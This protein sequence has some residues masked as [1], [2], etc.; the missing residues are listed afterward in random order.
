MDLLLN[1]RN[2]ASCAKCH[3]IFEVG[4][5]FR[6]AD[7]RLYCSSNCRAAVFV[8]MARSDAAGVIAQSRDFDAALELL[9]RLEWSHFAI[10]AVQ[11][12]QYPGYRAKACP[13]CH[14]VEDNA[15]NALYFPEPMLGHAGNCALAELLARG[16]IQP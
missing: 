7:G 6:G 13:F 11:Y 15:T 12:D 9:R 5:G 1:G 2:A 8:S 10:G 4:E 14:N 3:E 16:S